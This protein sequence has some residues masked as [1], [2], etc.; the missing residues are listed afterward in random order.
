M[1][2]TEDEVKRILA[3]VDLYIEQSAFNGL[4]HAHRI[5]AMVLLLR[6]TGMRISDVVGL[7][8][9]RI[10]GNRLLLYTQKLEFLCIPYSRS[11]SF[12]FLNQRHE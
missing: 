10:N 7:E 1:P 2:F 3:A 6:Y 4:Q 9:R 5:R 8:A 11:L 12:R